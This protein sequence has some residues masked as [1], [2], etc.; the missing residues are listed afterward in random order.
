MHGGDRLALVEPPILPHVGKIGGYQANPRRAELA[1]R[2]R[3]EEKWQ[4]LSVGPIQRAGHDDRSVPW[5]SSEPQIDLLVRET[6]CFELAEF[7]IDC[8]CKRAGEQLAP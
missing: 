3:R 2:L 1:R 4:H 5:L 6:A 8:G 7:A